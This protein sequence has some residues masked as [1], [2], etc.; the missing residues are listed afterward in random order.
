[1]LFI[2]LQF[3]HC[4]AIHGQQYENRTDDPSRAIQQSNGGKVVMN[5][6]FKIIN[7]V[8]YFTAANICKKT[9]VYTTTNTC[10]HSQCARVSRCIWDNVWDCDW[11]IDGETCLNV[12]VC[13]IV[14]VCGRYPPVEHYINKNFVVAV[15]LLVLAKVTKQ[16]EYN[17][18]KAKQHCFSCKRNWCTVIEIDQVTLFGDN[19]RRIMYSIYTLHHMCGV[20][21]YDFM[22]LC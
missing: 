8:A 16:Y 10:M 17:E 5:W 18:Y 1:M 14:W 13:A 6:V 20:V 2:Y 21:Y 7:I 4:A 15:V 19:Y 3:S 9:S 11:M 12:C 22:R